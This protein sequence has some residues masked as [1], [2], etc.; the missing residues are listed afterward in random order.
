MNFVKIDK[1]YINLDN[2]LYIK[3]LYV[4]DDGSVEVYFSNDNCIQLSIYS[5]KNL[6]KLIGEHDERA[7]F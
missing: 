7:N 3:P 4:I 1:Y 5:A 2:I 6:I